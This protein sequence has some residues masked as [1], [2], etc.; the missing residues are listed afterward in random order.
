MANKASS[1]ASNTVLTQAAG[2]AFHDTGND[3]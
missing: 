2:K 3:T 1:K